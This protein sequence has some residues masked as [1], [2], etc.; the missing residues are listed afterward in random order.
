MPGARS[1]DPHSPSYHDEETW[2]PCLGVP[3]L[4]AQT[5]L[6]HEAARELRVAVTVGLLASPPG[7]AGARCARHLTSDSRSL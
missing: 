1:G 7:K 5:V 3:G 6:W 2:N 4:E